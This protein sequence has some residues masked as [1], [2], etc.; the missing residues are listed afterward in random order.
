[1]TGAN[2]DDEAREE[3]INRRALELQSYMAQPGRTEAEAQAVLAEMRGLVA[4]LEEMG[5]ASKAR[6]RSLQRQAGISTKPKLT[7]VKAQNEQDS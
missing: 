5:R 3:A 2:D 1:M 4:E 7:V 6:L